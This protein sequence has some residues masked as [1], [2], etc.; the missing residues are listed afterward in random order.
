MSTWSD[1]GRARGTVLRGGDAATARSARMDSELRTTA[2]APSRGV[3]AR[4]TDPVLQDVVERARRAAEEQGRAS[5]HAAGY[6]AGFTAAERDAEHAA[7]RS[8]RERAARE[9][10]RVAQVAHAVDLL[11]AAAEEF[12]RKEQVAVADIEDAVVELALGI[13]RE[14]LGRELAVSADPGAEALSRALA[15]LPEG[16]PAT[17]R[18]HPADAASLIGLDDLARGRGVVLVADPAVERG[19]CLAEAAGRS[20]DTRVGPALERV[21]AALRGGR[22]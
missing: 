13:A 9:Q 15:L 10:A 12:T 18:L 2:F 19:G 5:G 8:E 20:V 17:V 14:V 22:S 16:A 1:S 21:A 4:L 7:A 3:D 11:A 6:A